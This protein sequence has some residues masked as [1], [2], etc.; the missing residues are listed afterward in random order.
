MQLILYGER[1]KG[2]VGKRKLRRR[3]WEHPFGDWERSRPF[4]PPLWTQPEPQTF[5]SDPKKNI[6]K[7]TQIMWRKWK[8]V[9]RERE[10]GRD[11]SSAEKSES[12]GSDWPAIAVAVGL[13]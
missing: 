13:C 12:W 11:T 7:A 9:H 6:I 4:R 5:Q 10:R 3:N 2:K 1:G 8:S